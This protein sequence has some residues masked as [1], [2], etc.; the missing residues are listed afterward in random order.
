MAKRYNRQALGVCLACHG[1]GTPFLPEDYR[2]ANLPV[3]TTEQ[4]TLCAAQDEER[5]RVREAA[6]ASKP[7]E[8]LPSEQ[9]LKLPVDRVY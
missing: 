5:A 6:K 7:A 4:L 8:N 9:G 2:R 3:P 1:D